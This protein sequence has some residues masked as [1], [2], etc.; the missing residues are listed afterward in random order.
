MK[1]VAR[2]KVGDACG[3]STQCALGNYYCK[4]YDPGRRK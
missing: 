3:G 4:G 1:C 2:G